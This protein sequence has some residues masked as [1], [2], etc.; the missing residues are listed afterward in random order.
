[1]GEDKMP[2]RLCFDCNFQTQVLVEHLFLKLSHEVI[3]RADSGVYG[4]FAENLRVSYLEIDRRP[5]NEPIGSSLNDVDSINLS[6][7][8]DLP[9]FAG[10]SHDDEER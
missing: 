9:Q 10:H 3:D 7:E 8:L 2:Y 1:M 6:V 4:Y 5:I